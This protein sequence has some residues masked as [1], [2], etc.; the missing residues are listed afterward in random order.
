[1]ATQTPTTVPTLLNDAVSQI[2]VQ[3]LEAASVVLAAGPKIFDTSSQL[4]VPRIA[5]TTTP[6]FIAPGGVIPDAAPGFDEI[7]LLPPA[8]KSLK[9][10]T[11]LTNE[12]I[13]QTVVGLDAIVRQRITADLASSLDI[14]LLTGAGTSNTIK[15]LVNQ[16][17][18]QTLAADPAAP[19][20][21]LTALG[22]L[23]SA[24]VKPSHI[25]ISPA[26]Y[27]ALRALKDA[28]GRYLIT[29]DATADGFERLF[30]V[31]LVITSRLATGKAVALDIQYVAVARDL[32]PSVSLD[33]S[34]YFDTDESA[35]RVV[36]R[37][38]IGLLQPKAVV[39]ITKA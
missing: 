3:P 28:D 14:A 30:G 29:T 16:A 38:D 34:R 11:R 21:F 32:A 19:D 2:V 31:P 36:A 7:V 5:T 39:V 33:T 22:L 10:L 12:A 4:R 23:R 25:F 8:L 9:T 18:V 15:G 37:F 6:G 20:T 26:D 27:F 13:R 17:G 24:E 1:M 35:I